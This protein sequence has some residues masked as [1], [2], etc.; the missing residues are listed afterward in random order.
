MFSI[1]E[2]TLGRNPISAWNVGKPSVRAH[3]LPYTEEFILERN[4]MNVVIVGKPSAGGQPS[5]NIRGSILGS[6][7][8]TESVVQPLFL[9][10]ALGHTDRCTLERNT[11]CVMDIAEPSA[12]ARTLFFI[13]RFTDVSCFQNQLPFEAGTS[14]LTHW[15]FIMIL[16]VPIVPPFL[17][18]SGIRCTDVAVCLS[19]PH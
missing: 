6:P 17:L 3:S 9:G 13:G 16:R 10:P 12:V 14:H 7:V 15:R 19:V 5:L 4:P 1:E 2:F 8:H 11:L 18:H